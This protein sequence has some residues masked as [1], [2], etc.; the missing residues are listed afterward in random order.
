[1]VKMMANM[2]GN[3]PVGRELLVHLAKYILRFNREVLE[4]TDRPLHLADHEPRFYPIPNVSRFNKL[5]RLKMQ[6][7]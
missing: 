5:S 2:H 6:D 1:M 3:E 7:I 4:T